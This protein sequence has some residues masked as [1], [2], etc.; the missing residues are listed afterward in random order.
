MKMSSSKRLLDSPELNLVIF[1]L[2]LH[3]AWE[4]LQVPLFQGAEEARYIEALAVCLL[5]TFGDAAIVVAAFWGV[6]ARARPGRGW[7]LSPTIRH[8]AWFTLIGVL[9][10][11]VFELLATKVWNRWSYGELMPVIPLLDVG[12]SP[13]LQWVVLQPLIVWVVRRQIT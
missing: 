13:L 10:T 5:A 3:F 2:L 9:I 11:I 8:I 4:M 1:A 6:A 7:L 12:L